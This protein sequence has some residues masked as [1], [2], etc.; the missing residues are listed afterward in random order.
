MNALMVEIFNLVQWLEIHISKFFAPWK[1]LHKDEGFPRGP[2]NL[3]MS[4][5]F[6]GLAH[7]KKGYICISRIIA[8]VSY[9]ITLYTMSKKVTRSVKK[10]TFCILSRNVTHYIISRKV[11]LFYL[12]KKCDPLSRNVTLCFMSWKVT[13]SVLLRMVTFLFHAKKV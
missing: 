7:D 10:V 4:S 5:E 12:I 13:L 6:T 1:M 9:Y 3:T 11:T 2:T 8:P